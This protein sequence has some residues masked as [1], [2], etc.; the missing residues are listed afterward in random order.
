MEAVRHGCLALDRIWRAQAAGGVH[1]EAW[2]RALQVLYWVEPHGARAA[3]AF[4]R[5]S[6]KHVDAILER[7][8]AQAE[9]HGP[10]TCGK[11]HQ[12]LPQCCDRTP[13]QCGLARRGGR[14]PSPI[15]FAFR[16]GSGG[17]RISGGSAATGAAPSAERARL[18]R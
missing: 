1:E 5:L 4:S 16:G 9:A 11:F 13:E 17:G 2:F 3:R 15:R 6:A 10:T 14:E 8:L 12:A 7:K 18:D